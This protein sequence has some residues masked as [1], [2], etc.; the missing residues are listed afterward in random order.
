MPSS[1]EL[2]T[3]KAAALAAGR[4]RTESGLLTDVV[5]H[6]SRV[7]GTER[8]SI[9]L[10][11]DGRL[12]TGAAV[13][14]P[15]DYLAAVDGLEIGPH[16]GTC[17]KAAFLGRT[18]V[19][20]DIETDPDW[21][22]GRPAAAAA[23][24]R[25]CWSVPL[26]QGDGTVVGTFAGYS[27]VPCEPTPTQLEEAEALAALVALGME[28]FRH[29]ERLAE[30]Y[31][32]VVVALTSA[33]DSRDEYTA[34]HSSETARL[35]L[36]VGR[37]MG[38]GDAELRR[39]EQV[40]TLHDIGKLGVPTQILQSTRP[41][42]AEEWEIVRQHPV[43][44]EQILG[45]VPHLVDV[46]KAVRHEHE[47]WDGA[48]YPDGLAGDRIP[49]ASRIVFACDAWHAMTSDRP[50]RVAMDRASA[51]QELR[52]NAGSQFDPEVVDHVLAALGAGEGA[53]HERRDER[54]RARV[55]TLT[56]MTRELGADDLFIF[57]K[58]S[59]DK[60]AHFG[61]AG[62]GEGWAGNVELDAEQDEEHF[63][64]ALAAGRPVRVCFPEPRRLVGPYYGASAIFVPCREDLVVVFG[65]P[66][67]ALAAASLDEATVLAE[68]AAALVGEIAPAKRL[69]DEL[70]VLE[71][72]RSITTIPA[73][74]LQPTLAAIA[75]RAATALSCEFG[76]VVAFSTNGEPCVG[77]ADL[78]FMPADPEEL[79]RVL[80]PLVSDELELP[81][82]VQDCACASDAPAALAA[83]GATSIH[84]LAVGPEPLA[85]LLMVHADSVPR[86]FTMLCQR[87]AGAISDAAEVVIRRALAQEE[88]AAEKERLERRVRTDSLTGVASRAA[89]DE[90]LARE[91]LHIA[92]SHAP[93]SIVLFDLDDL[94]VA[95]DEEGHAA[96]DRLLR[97]CAGVLAQGSRATDLV[98]RLGGDEFAALLRYT[99]EKSARH[100]C[101]RIDEAIT[102]H[103]ARGENRPLS[104]AYGV[105]S[106]PPAAD[107]AAALAEAD[108]RMYAAKQRPRS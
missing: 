28:R 71:A 1:A 16:V 25:S 65:S 6:M 7:T 34:N 31:E 51:V 32:S 60:F 79:D 29:E 87:V 12:R 40:A 36:A 20:A 9:L 97:A 2:D 70:E 14:L 68:R 82:L 106:V 33:L 96:G 13:G 42:T 73:H 37:R 50:Y 44:G 24:L 59:P 67:G 17:G 47:R 90:A 43:I 22:A 5:G 48:G 72:V 18:V 105:A 89:W 52:S 101:E 4:A 80:V 56:S 100:W 41:L 86:G 66:N 69:A 38:L 91:E 27:D 35:A 103:N 94:K 81:F 3:F 99:D 108:A 95:N 19:T 57:R 30:S 85:V 98:A 53:V 49:L 15:D 61:G 26:R 74:R 77:H 46:A 62:R 84:A 39:L 88:L 54:E 8:C 10:L 83:R 64:A 63:V 21:E 58:V 78:G 11:Q 93:T 92:R 55:D 102:A 45:G 104:V 23:G 107:L 75:D 76:A